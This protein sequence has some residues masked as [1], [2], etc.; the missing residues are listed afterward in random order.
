MASDPSHAR[1][2][3]IDP[4]L[5]NE[6][7]RGSAPQTPRWG[8]PP[9]RPPFAMLPLALACMRNLACRGL[10]APSTKLSSAKGETS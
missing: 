6:L 2:R 8:T 7:L 3:F 4:S 1:R 10:A 9:P 5:G